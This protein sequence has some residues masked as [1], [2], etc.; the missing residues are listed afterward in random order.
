MQ[1]MKTQETFKITIENPC[2]QN[3]E[4]MEQKGNG[5]F[6]TSCTKVVVDLNSM[7][8]SQI[9][10]FLLKQSASVCGRIS[11]TRITTN[12][13]Y[14]QKNTSR[15]NL[16]LL[17]YSI[18]GVLTLSSVKAYSQTTNPQNGT[19]LVDNAGIKKTNGTDVS[20]KRI[21]KVKVI[22]EDSSLIPNATVKLRCS[23]WKAEKIGGQLTF[24]IPD[25]LTETDFILMMSAPGHEPASQVL[26]MKTL[27]KEISIEKQLYHEIMLMG[28]IAPPPKKKGK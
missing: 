13:Y 17:R 24:E 23:N 18:A 25:S 12:F 6:C 15:F 20:G 10:D 3:W 21:V 28:V 19:V 8:D 22:N 11:K 7:T 16:A 27:P 26:D 2:G 14:P 1:Q 4:Q 5:R 9:A